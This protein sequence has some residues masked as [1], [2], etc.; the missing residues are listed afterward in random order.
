MNH[1]SQIL[2]ICK[3]T[4]VKYLYSG[5]QLQDAGIHGWIIQKYMLWESGMDSSSSSREHSRA[6]RLHEKQQVLEAK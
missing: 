3:K 2:Q 6:F 1:A 5:D 4:L